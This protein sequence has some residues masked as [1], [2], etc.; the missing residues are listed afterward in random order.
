MDDQTNRLSTFLHHKTTHQVTPEEE[1]QAL[2]DLLQGYEPSP[3]N[4]LDIKG[5]DL[6][7]VWFDVRGYAKE[8]DEGHRGI[9]AR[10]VPLICALCLSGG[11]RPYIHNTTPTRRREQGHRPLHY[12]YLF[13]H[14]YHIT[15]E[16]ILAGAQPGTEVRLGEHHRDLRQGLKVSVR[17]ARDR[18]TREAAVQAALHFYDEGRVTL[19]TSRADYEALLRAAFDY[20]DNGPVLRGHLKAAAE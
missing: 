6:A 9:A 12:V 2:R 11:R 7:E 16:R 3:F 4:K 15:L 5:L 20:L 13:E 8:T 18:K 1:L 14:P 19:P 10:A 17:S